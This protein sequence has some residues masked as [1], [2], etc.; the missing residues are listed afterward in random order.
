MQ[1]ASVVSEFPRVWDGIS[2]TDGGGDGEGDLTAGEQHSLSR[3]TCVHD[4]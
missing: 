2:H 3:L 1:T 4:G